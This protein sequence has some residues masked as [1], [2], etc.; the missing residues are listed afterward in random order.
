MPRVET[1]DTL[2]DAKVVDNACLALSRIAEAFSHRP[3]SLS[4]LCDSGIITNAIQLVRNLPLSIA[5]VLHQHEKFV[6]SICSLTLTWF[7]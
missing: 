4:M 5:A 6:T 3:A 1:P 2:Q 7:K